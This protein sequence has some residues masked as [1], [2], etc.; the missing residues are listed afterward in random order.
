[1]PAEAGLIALYIVDA[2]VAT[3]RREDGLQLTED[4]LKEFITANLN[5]HAIT[6]L[7]YLRDLLPTSNRPR[8]TVNRVRSYVE[9]LRTGPARLFLPLDPKAH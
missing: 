8:Q 4:V 1:M 3:G 2:L 7:A 5:Q 6:A 9:R